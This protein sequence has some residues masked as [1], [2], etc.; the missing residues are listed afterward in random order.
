MLAW[1]QDPTLI[2]NAVDDADDGEGGGSVA[3]GAA[4]AADAATGPSRMTRGAEEDSA[5]VAGGEKEKRLVLDESSGS[6]WES[7]DAHGC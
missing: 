1:K 7:P 4:F 3:D 5:S 6:D 2:K